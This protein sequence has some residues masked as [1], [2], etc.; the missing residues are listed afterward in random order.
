[1]ELRAER[2]WRRPPTLDLWQ[3]PTLRRRMPTLLDS[4]DLLLLFGLG[5]L[6]PFL[7]GLPVQPGVIVVLRVIV[8]VP[9]LLVAPGFALVAALFPGRGDLDG[10]S[11]A[12]LSFGLSIA[13]I[14]VLAAV[15][16][17]GPW[18]I[19]PLPIALAL[20]LWIAVFGGVAI[21]RRRLAFSRRLRLPSLAPDRHPWALDP[22][23]HAESSWKLPSGR[24]LSSGLA[25]VLAVTAFAGL[26]VLSID[27]VARTTEFYM[28][29]ETGQ[30]EHYPGIA[31]PNQPLAV[32][33]GLANHERAARTYQ[34]EVWSVDGGNPD[35]QSLLVQADQITLKPGEQ[36]EQPVTW[37]MPAPGTY[38]VEF[39]L[40]VD[41][42]P[43]GQNRV[44][45]PYRRLDLWVDVAA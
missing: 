26:T 20:S 5:A 1:M 36:H 14:A 16:G 30:A 40:F 2:Q 19:R 6:L 7:P 27:R 39:R 38:R 41:G 29:G 23:V 24:R 9:A 32:T 35:E 43:A 28:L 3:E 34:I 8:G 25:A 21:V 37:Q 22:P 18:G 42:A 15:L 17:L 31:A 10:Q 44:A 45:E 33:I 11:R 4:Y 12:A 13:A